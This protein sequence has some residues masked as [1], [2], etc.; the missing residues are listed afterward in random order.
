[1][2]AEEDY[3]ETEDVRKVFFGHLKSLGKDVELIDL[4]KLDIEKKPYYSFCF[5]GRS[6]MVDNVGCINVKGQYFDHIHLLRLG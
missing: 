1:M 3:L 4:G 6:S 5:S 2:E